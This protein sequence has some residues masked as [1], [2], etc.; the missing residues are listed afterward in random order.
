[1]V[2]PDTDVAKILFGF[3]YEQLYGRD[4]EEIDSRW[5]ISPRDFFQKFGTDYMQYQF[6]NIYPDT[7]EVIP[8][9]C[10]WV[11]RF[12]FWYQEQK[13]KDPNVK[14]VITK[15]TMSKTFVVS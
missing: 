6:P 9:K 13:K 4:K 10:L 5:N 15:Y 11:K 3:N 12:H 2:D 1:M 8:D 7:K 14:I